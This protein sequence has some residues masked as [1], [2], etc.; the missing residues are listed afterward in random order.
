VLIATAGHVDHGKTSLVQALTGVDTD[1]LP[2]EK[3]RGLTIDLGFAYQ[4]L[5]SGVQLGFV[6]VPG[7]ER[8][9]RN[10]I[11][12]V[13]A[14]DFAL[15]VVA[16]DDG[17]MPQTV[18]HLAIL[19]LLGVSAGAVVI[20]KIDRVEAARVE[21]V[22][23]EITALLVD[24]KQHA[25]PMFAV[26]ALLG[27]G[28]DALR[29]Y[30]EQAANALAPA[31]QDGGLRFAIDRSFSV[32]GAGLVA[33]G[34]VYAGSARIGD[35]LMLAGHE[36]EVR[37]RGME[38]GGMPVEVVHCGMRCALN[39]AGRGVDA[40][41]VSRGDWV[42]AAEAGPV[43][44]RIDVELS[45]L[46]SEAAPL[47][48]W[49]P[50][51]VHHGAAFVTARVTLPGGEAIRPGGEGLAQIVTDRPICAVHGERIVLRDTSGRRTLGGAT[52]IDPYAPRRVRDRAAR[53]R[54]LHELREPE[55]A[56]ALA[57]ALRIASDGV[58]PQA[59]ANARNID[60]AQVL[61]QASTTGAI[62]IETEL[63]SRVLMPQRWEAV[64]AAIVEELSRYHDE[65]PEAVGLPETEL[66]RR[67]LVAS[68]RTLGQAGVAAMLRAAQIMRDG[69]NLRLPTHRAR[70]SAADEALWLR[71]SQHF[72]AHTIKPLTSGD[73][74]LSLAI[75]LPALLAFLEA[76]ARR[77][78]LVRVARNRF[79][80]PKAIAQLAQSAQQLA[81]AAGAKG[82]D[83]RA[84]RDATAIGRNLSIE[85]LE[86]FDSMG[87]T[88]RVGETRQLIGDSVKVFGKATD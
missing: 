44:N 87:L 47:K 23:E 42:V 3:T 27:T 64:Q 88:R 63:G 13:P 69:I 68:E 74:A 56:I 84:Y 40:N 30:L 9:I 41:S 8:F 33:T 72:D 66:I 6:D 39:L 59:F 2:E 7:H 45:L 75:E 83:A 86:F 28:M 16:A 62:E 60:C 4:T 38:S 29:E 53:L 37:V 67:T 70:L 25:A 81:L 78:Q 19:D 77:G 48:Q 55:L 34:A 46:P 36:L 43:S 5:D 20:T 49:T 50:V 85:V 51:H 54:L 11:A 82:F 52:V 18:E 79:F 21:Q 73:L 26:A 10:M 12:G 76:C 24:S 14:I 58:D 22:R 65:Q 17:P 1:R 80:H 35:R 57:A 32:H 61:A 71:V 15:L 31:Q